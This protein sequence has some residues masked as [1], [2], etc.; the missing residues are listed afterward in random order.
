MEYV[1]IFDIYRMSVIIKIKI[2]SDTHTHMH[3]LDQKKI[4][5]KRLF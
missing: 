3:T 2:I 5:E 4:I 1:M